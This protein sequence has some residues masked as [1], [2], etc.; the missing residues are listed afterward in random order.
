MKLVS[1]LLISASLILAPTAQA[2]PN[3]VPASSLQDRI[4]KVIAREK[5]KRIDS[6]KPTPKSDPRADLIT[7]ANKIRAH[8]GLPP[9][10]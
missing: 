9:L 2:A 8:F 1:A 7:G 6:R 10:P 3:L 4:D 5:Q